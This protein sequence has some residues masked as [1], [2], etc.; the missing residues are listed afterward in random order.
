MRTTARSLAS[1]LLALFFAGMPP[2][3][4][5][6]PVAPYRTGLT[7]WRAAAGDFQD[8]YL[9]GV[10]RMPD[11]SLALDTAGAYA[12]HDPYRA[13][14]YHGHNYFNGGGFLIGEAVSPITR[15]GFRFSQLIPSWNAATPAGTWIETALRARIGPHWTRWFVVAVW[16]AGDT[17][18]ARH[19][20]SSRATPDGRVDVDTLVLPDDR[21]PANAFQARVR[22]FTIDAAASPRV[23][24]AAVAWSTSPSAPAAPPPG[25]PALWDHTLAVPACSQMVYPDGGDI[26]CSPTSTAMILAYWQGDGGPCEPRVRAAVAGVFD[27]LYDGHG[28]W[29]FNT[30]YAATQGFEAYVVRFAGLA[31][32]EPWIAGGVP[33]AI[34]FA[35]GPGELDG[36]ALPASTGHLAVLIGFDAQGNPVVNDPAAGDNATVRRTYPRAQLERLWLETSGGAAYVIYPAGWPVP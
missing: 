3:Q 8:W 1:L 17:H 21:G 22:L 20:L 24:S 6:M 28:N 14:G 2:A 12:R 11:G 7:R 16:A 31:E 4:A 36:A 32:A 13:S 34:T 5:A 15:P 23:Y 19:S 26:W 10:Q 30:A 35:W 29:P 9:N 33:I 25:D 18:V 27:W